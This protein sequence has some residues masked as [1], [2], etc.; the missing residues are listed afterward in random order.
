MHCIITAGGTVS[1]DDP[2]YVYTQGKPKSLIR[3]GDKPMLQW[4]IEALK[5]SN[6][7]EQIYVVGIEESEVSHLQLP[8]DI[9]YLPDSGGLVSNASASLQRLLADHPDDEV[10]LMCSADVPM[11]TT[12]VVDAYI[13]DCRPFDHIAYYN[14][15]SKATLEARFPQSRRTFVKLKGI[16]VTGGDMTLAQTRI[17]QTNEAL[18]EAIVQG[19]K[20]AW[21]LVR[22]VGIRPLI[23]FLFRQLTLDDVEQMASRVLNAPVKVFNSPYPELA[24]DVDKPQQVE[25]LRHW[26]EK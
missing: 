1:E 11:L 15:V 10:V 8:A 22:I 12:K 16:S 21:K 25:L 3:F 2:L 9:I 14:V 23:K 24:M 17:L 18:W 4:V 19:R 20:Q 6:H 5:G 7:I 26:L 13:N